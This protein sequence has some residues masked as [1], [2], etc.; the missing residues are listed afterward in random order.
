MGGGGGVVPEEGGSVNQE[1]RGFPGVR[2][3]EMSKE[4]Q[5][6][7]LKTQLV[8]Q[9]EGEFKNISS[10]NDRPANRRG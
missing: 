8:W 10:R 6:Q 2:R 5:E 3:C 7:G 9:G 4:E 1:R